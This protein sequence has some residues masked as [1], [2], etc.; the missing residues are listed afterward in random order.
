MKTLLRMGVTRHHQ[1]R[2]DWRWNPSAAFR[3]VREYK[4]C[5]RYDSVSPFA[6]CLAL[7]LVSC[8]CGLCSG[9]G[10]QAGSVRLGLG[11]GGRALRGLVAIRRVHLRHHG[12]RMFKFTQRDF[13]LNV[14]MWRIL[15][16]AHLTLC[17]YVPVFSNRTR[18]SKCGTSAS[19]A[20]AFG[21]TA[22]APRGG[23]RFSGWTTRRSRSRA[24]RARSTC[25]TS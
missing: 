20:S 2:R 21:R 9:H 23:S 6:V 3:T 15:L 22:S 16:R 25:T 19:R 17:F 13:W 10:G 24:T 11:L 7:W 8:C 5:Y 12:Q 14:H 1:H 18:F 4:C